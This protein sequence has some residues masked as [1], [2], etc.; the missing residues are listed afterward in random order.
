MG[1][2]DLTVQL[3]L[4][5]RRPPA[6]FHIPCRV[7]DADP[8]DLRIAVI[9]H[10]FVQVNGE[11]PENILHG[12]LIAGTQH[13]V[14][15]A[16]DIGQFRNDVHIA[17]AFTQRLYHRVGIHDHGT[18]IPLELTA[19]QRC[20][21]GQHDVRPLGAVGHEQ[22]NIHEEIEF[23]ERLKD[24]L[25]FRK[26]PVVHAVGVQ[27]L[28]G[29]FILVQDVLGQVVGLHVPS[30]FIPQRVHIGS[31]GFVRVLRVGFKHEVSFMRLIS[32]GPLGKGP[33]TRVL[34]ARRPDIAGNRQ[35]G[36][37][38]AVVLHAVVMVRQRGG[39]FRDGHGFRVP[40]H[41]H[42]FPDILFRHPGQFL[43]LLQG[44][45]LN[46]LGVLLEPV[47]VLFN[48]LSVNPA[49]SNQLIGH[50]Q[51]QGPV[52]AQPRPQV[53]VGKPCRS[54]GNAR[55]HHDIFEAGQLLE[56]F[57]PLGQPVHRVVA[58]GRPADEQLGHDAHAHFH[59]GRTLPGHQPRREAGRV[60]RTVTLRAEGMRKPGQ[61]APV[62]L[63]VSG[64]EGY[65]VGPIC[66]LDAVEL[67]RDLGIGLF[68]GDPLELPLA[69]LT[70]AAQR[71]EQPVLTVQVFPVG[72]PFRAQ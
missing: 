42:R 13:R 4:P 39:A 27:G 7:F 51:G 2:Y 21:A 20:A 64:I 14:V 28:D 67:C 38:A 52:R 50:G 72:Q 43:T 22:V 18:R 69:P 33:L 25:I 23:L 66:R 49:V 63:V 41:L 48:I 6:V 11:I 26:H 53:Q 12:I 35:Q 5:G 1:P 34:P 47:D 44:V 36:H 9:C 55:V 24:F 16:H 19:F 29:V 8:F 32:G 30:Q 56:L 37:D 68:P 45:F 57:D 10:H 58:V 65:L 60:F 31:D 61:H 59:A 62:P 70:N 71:V 15:N 3:D 17:L 40:D 54:R 46:T